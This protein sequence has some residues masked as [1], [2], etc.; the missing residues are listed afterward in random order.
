MVFANPLLLF[1]LTAL[2][3][4][5]LIHLFNFRR[6]RKIY[7]TNVRFLSAIKQETRKR[8]EIRQLLILL[9]RLLAVASLVLAFA[10]PYIPSPLRQKKLSGQQA[11]SVY[12]DNSFSMEAASREGKLLEVAKSR[13]LE[14]AGA[15]NP[16]D[17]FLLV[18]N[19]TGSRYNLP[20][21]RDEFI[22]M[23][24]EV[25]LSTISVP[26]SVILLRQKEALGRIATS[27]KT[28]YLISDFQ[29]ATS[30]LPMFAS[31]TLHS[32][33][34]VP[35]VP[36]KTNNL[37][38]DSAWFESPVQQP[39]QPSVLMVSV[40]NAG[41]E[42]VEKVPLKLTINGRQK[43]VSGVELT[44]G[45]SRVLSLPFTNE[46]AGHQQGYA[47]ITD[48]PVV[49]DNT[50]Y[51]SYSL[52]QS[53]P[54]LSINNDRGNP[55]LEALFGEDSS[56]SYS[57]VPVTRLDYS[58][59]TRFPIIILDGLKEISSGL[60]QELGR[61]VR[62]GG[63]LAVFPPRDIVRES[64]TM[65]CAAM[66]LPA[67]GRPDTTAFR[68]ERINTESALF[69]DV[70]EKNASGKVVL[71]E[72]TDLPTAFFHFG[73]NGMVHA[74]GEMLMQLE[75]GDPFLESFS[76]GKGKVYL[77]TAPLDPAATNFPKHPLFVP[78]LFKMVLLS[79]TQPRLYYYTG[80]NEPVLI[81]GDTLS[82]RTVYKI[83]KENGSF[84]IIPEMRSTGSAVLLFP[85]E[86]IR[87]AGNY[88]VNRDGELL[89]WVSFN[90]SRKESDPVLLATGE[91]T[92]SLKK[93]GIKYFV[94]LKDNKTPV[95][96]QVREFE[97]GKPLWKLFIILALVFIA[98]EI[99]IIRL[100][101]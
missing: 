34:L 101:K 21:S 45:A 93:A 72:N 70:F 1:G 69:S 88:T 25:E 7:F 36:G 100:I 94:I 39:T 87:E 5:I 76:Q 37:F 96:K 75:N 91:I 28:I 18:T 40:K 51:F 50:L 3:I 32:Y 63:Q 9:S 23:V 53:L 80:S 22:T 95:S 54:V 41:T 71:A 98:A 89:T 20:V 83:R 56:F 2:A 4:P 68:V 58:S 97:R 27:N 57:E 62:N 52:L 60:S 43:A 99:F 65:F 11:V 38:I 48:N 59:L 31:D 10:Q 55:Y 13:A 49:F 85:R 46:G 33:L 42:S 15:C 47:E 82:N 90:Y 73:S 30:D 17:Q 74:G 6:Y 44:P 8:S 14:I 12:I 16:S 26:M 77:F 92:S 66:A 61:Y 29:R 84:E 64:Y 78:V 79:E 86:Q 35:L 24:R 81:T 19:Q 67:F